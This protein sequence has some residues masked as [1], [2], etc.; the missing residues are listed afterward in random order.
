MFKLKQFYHVTCSYLLEKQ[1]RNHLRI[2]NPKYVSIH[3]LCYNCLKIKGRKKQ[4]EIIFVTWTI[5]MVLIFPC[6]FTWTTI[7]IKIT[8]YTS[9]PFIHVTSASLSLTSHCMTAF[10]L[11]VASTSSSFLKKSHSGSE[12]EIDFR[13]AFL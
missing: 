11:S 6:I 7:R 3:C 5:V 9:F 1:K 8:D 12:I 10:S 2:L 13:I 4:I